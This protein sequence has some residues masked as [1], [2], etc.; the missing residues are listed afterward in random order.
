MKILLVRVGVD[1]SREGGGWNAPV[2]LTTREFA[3]VAIPESHDVV[4]GTERSYES[5]DLLAEL[6]KFG[7]PL[8]QHLRGRHMHLDPD[9]ERCTYGDQGRRASQLRILEPRDMI[10][11][12]AGLRAPDQ[13]QLVYA[14]IGQLTVEQIKRAGDI[15]DRDMNAH[16]RRRQVRPDDLVV[17]GSHSGSGRYALCIPIGEYRDRAYRVRRDL[18]DAWGKISIKDGY[19]QRSGHLPT[20]LQPAQFHHWLTEQDVALVRRNY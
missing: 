17:I 9:F 3:Y 16:T 11:F 6:R 8:P 15:A 7:V 19:L 1:Q 4:R 18:L 5:P 10:V 14:L 12:Y 20:M 2:N 13:G